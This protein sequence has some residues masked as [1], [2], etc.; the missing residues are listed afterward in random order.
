V[1]PR[2]EGVPRGAR[3]VRQ[4]GYSIWAVGA[5]HAVLRDAYHTFLRIPWSASIGLIA[6]A[7]VVVNL[8]FAVV[9]FFVG[10]VAGL[11]PTSFFDALVFSV[12]TIGTIGY[13]VMHPES[14][15][16]NIVMII[17]SIAGIIFTALVTGLVFAKFSR[18]TAR[19]AFSTTAVICQHEG[20]PTLIFRVGNRRS[21]VIVEANIHVVASMTT[22]TKEGAPFYRLHD[23]KLVR[24]RL[25]GMRRGWMVMHPI[26]EA[27][28]LHGLGA[29]EFKQ[30][31]LEL[32]I[33]MLGFDDV[34]LQTVHAMHQYADGQIIVGHKFADTLT[35]LAN[36]DMVLDLTKFDAT[37]PDVR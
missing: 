19:I 22:T 15:A 24:S 14:H 26:D 13:G 1:P 2:P 31:E 25:G 29:E 5:E 27:S 17:E 10:G 4:I 20:I 16:A 9:Y 18:A 37:V 33:S 32:E 6:L 12:Q 23:L 34:T 28:P 8:V 3:E 36:G 21:N 7:F 35:M 30:R 11:N